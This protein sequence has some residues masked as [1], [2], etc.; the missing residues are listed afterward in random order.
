MSS[1]LSLGAQAATLSVANYIELLVIDGKKL[2]KVDG[3]RLKK[4]N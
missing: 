4:L 3:T 2:S 1:V